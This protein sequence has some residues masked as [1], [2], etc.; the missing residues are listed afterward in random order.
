[1]LIYCIRAGYARLIAI[2]LILLSTD[3][4]F[5]DKELVRAQAPF[6]LNLMAVLAA[7]V[8]KVDYRSVMQAK[9]SGGEVSARD[10]LRI[11][12]I[13]KFLDSSHFKLNVVD[14]VKGKGSNFASFF[15]KKFTDFYKPVNAILKP[16]LISG[17]VEK[18]DSALL[19]LS[20]SGYERLNHDLTN[21]YHY[22][23]I[24]FFQRNAGLKMQLVQKFETL[25]EVSPNVNSRNTPLMSNFVIIY[26]DPPKRAGAAE[27]EPSKVRQE[28]VTY[29]EQKI[30]VN[31]KRGPARGT[32]SDFR[33]DYVLGILLIRKAIEMVR[34][35]SYQ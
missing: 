30:R 28:C 18:L 20:T 15:T 19:N 9:G 26:Q 4:E 11:S 2:T 17:D 21:W 12:D 3:G 27:E 25:L 16:T 23:L 13:N 1:M 33:S 34:S 7:N 35:K 8:F 6:L 22:K 29:I 24:P 10:Y 14:V 32:D 31:N 5:I